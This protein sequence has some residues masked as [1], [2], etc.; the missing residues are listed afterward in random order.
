MT[1]PDVP[2]VVVGGG[3]VGLT[4]ALE[5]A[6]HGVASLIVE[7]RESVEHSR[8]RAKTT[9]ARTMELFRRIGAADEI[10]RRAPLPVSWSQDVRFCTTAAGTEIT[11]FTGVLGLEL[12]GSDLTAEAAQQVTQP[13]VEEALRALI[14]RQPLV[15]TRFGSRVTA[16]DLSGPRPRVTTTDAA[17]E[18]SVV[19]ADY[20]VGADGSHSVVRAALGARYVGAAG[21]RPNVNITFRSRRL[22]ELVPPAIH[23]WVLNPAAPGVVGPL[24][25][26]G[27]WWAIATGTESIADEAEAAA[28]VRGLVGADVDVEVLATDPWQARLLLADSYGSGRAYL[29]GDAAHQNPPWGGHGFNTGVGDAVNLAFKL[30]AVLHGWAPAA[31]LD[32]YEDERRP[33]AQQTIDL[34]ATNM[35]NLSIDLT[36]PALMADGPEGEA[37]RA[38]AAQTIQATK[39]DEFHALGL[40]LGYGYGPDAAAQAP[41]TREY[42]PI[43]APGNRLPHDRNAAGDSLFDLLGPEFTVLGPAGPEWA[44]AAQARGIPLRVVDPV[45]HGFAPVAGDRLVLV[46]PDQHIAWIGGAADDAGTALDAAVRGFPSIP[47]RAAAA[48]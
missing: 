13:V 23:H 17:G 3:P 29:V 2:V 21:G 37:A 8:P 39:R 20:V 43:A 45:V 48:S 6:H 47:S 28:L 14:G 36:S 4:T 41:S 35:R 19:T 31:L 26:D 15:T 11:R 10:R 24:D 32:S 34:A 22:A 38:A 44:Q 9:S 16:V 12:V 46:R 25:L 7:P 30:A 33:I 5:L 27:T 1:G 42:V 18:A 40:V